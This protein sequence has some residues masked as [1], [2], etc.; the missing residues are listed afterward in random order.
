MTIV[1]SDS[2]GISRW[3]K[4]LFIVMARNATSPIVH[5]RLPGE[6]TVIMGSQVPL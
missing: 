5:F 1:Q 2:P 4:S 6:R 3:R